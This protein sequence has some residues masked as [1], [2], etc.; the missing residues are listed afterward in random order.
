MPPNFS[1]SSLMNITVLDFHSGPNTNCSEFRLLM[2]QLYNVFQ[3]NV[4]ISL[5]LCIGHHKMWSNQFLSFRQKCWMPP[6]FS[7][8]LL[9]NITILDFHCWPNTNCSEF[10][11]PMTQL[12]I[13]FQL[14]ISISLGLCICHHK[15]RSDRIFSI[16]QTCWMPPNFSASSLMNIRILDFHSRPNTNCSA[17]RLP[18]TQLYKVFQSNVSISLDLCIGH[19]QMWSNQFLSFRQKRWMLPNFSAS[20]LMNITILD[21]HCWPNTNCSEFRLPMTQLY[22]V[23]QLNISI[24]LDL[25]ICHHKMWSNQ[26]F[27]MRQKWWM[28]PNLS[29]SSL[30][31]ITILD[32][33]SGPN[34]NCSEFR[35]PMTQLYKVF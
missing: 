33:H 29:A 30:M 11:L 24:S 3:S 23:F 8:S 26:I 32:F 10:S 22:I 7:A 21:F 20:L 28:P 1:A 13:V 2:R 18:M 5:D 27:S 16:R 9:M 17:F 35:L 6:N 15:M 12:Y 31:N 19:H 14:N 34:A 4:S 25:C